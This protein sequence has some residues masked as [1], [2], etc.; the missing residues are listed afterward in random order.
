MV[1]VKKCQRA[2]FS[3]IIQFDV[4]DCYPK[5]KTTGKKKNQTT[6]ILN[7]YNEQL[8]THYCL[9]LEPN[10]IQSMCILLS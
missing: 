2:K 5:T 8:S 6:N 9:V 4:P 3:K 10:T 7:P 1:E